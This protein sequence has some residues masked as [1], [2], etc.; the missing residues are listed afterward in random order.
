MRMGTRR[1]AGWL[2]L[3]A[4]LTIGGASLVWGANKGPDSASYT[5]TDAAV[6]SFIDVAGGSGGASV[7][8]GVDDGVALLTLPFPFQFYGV[9]YSYV[10]VSSNG[11]AYFVTGAGGCPPVN[12]LVDF[13]NTDLTATAAPGDAP[14]ILPFWS[15]LTFN[16]AGAGAV[17]YQT[18]GAPGSRQFVIEWSNAYPQGSANP[19]TFEAVLYEGSNNILFQYQTVDLGAGNAATGGKLSTVGIR[20]PGGNANGR[21]IEWSYN[22]AVLANSTAIRFSPPSSAQQSVNTITSVPAGLAVSID[23][24]SY[25]TP[26]VVSWTPNSSHTLAV[27]T[28]QVNGGTQNSFTGWSGGSTASTAQIT[29]QAA[30]TGTTYTANFATQYQLTTAT[31]PASGGS[32]AGAGWYTAGTQAT[33]SATP[34]SNYALAYFSG[35]LTGSVN[36]QNLL[37]DGPKNVVANFQST[38]NPVLTAAVSGK[39]NGTGSQRVWTIRLA[40]TGAGTATNAQITGMT[41]T[42]AA[43]TPCAPAPSILTSF[44]VSVGSI[45]PSA[46]ATG[47]VTIDFGGC[48][49]ST[50]RFTAVVK[51]AAGSYS[52]STTISNQPK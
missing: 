45:A 51:F 35:D 32:I 49:D 5:A 13:A 41:L 26:K 20:A 21:Q 25:A 14:A 30:D 16:V 46:N 50:A 11:L 22:A 8:A 9:S 10:C 18:K 44:P 36:P 2:R 34:A 6:Y 52:G 40:D 33:V 27:V 7:L 19:V 15:D 4:A 28:P 31:N 29:F 17:Y 43:G 38:A 48:A 23:G 24:V 39:A 47:N 3:A 1:P 12:P 42:Q 37:M